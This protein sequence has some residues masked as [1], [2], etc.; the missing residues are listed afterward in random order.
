M[1]HNTAGVPEWE[2]ENGARYKTD[3]RRAEVVVAVGGQ[4]GQAGAGIVG[5]LGELVVDVVFVCEVV[6]GR[7]G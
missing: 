3:L 2:V 5:D 4:G 6:G 1:R 7:P